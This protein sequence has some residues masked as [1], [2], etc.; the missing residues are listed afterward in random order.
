MIKIV[1][2]YEGYLSL[3]REAKLLESKKDDESLENF[4]YRVYK[5]HHGKL[6]TI[7]HHRIGSFLEMGVITP[8]GKVFIC[9]YQ[10]LQNLQSE[11]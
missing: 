9:G 4:V 1:N 3:Y 6:I 11:N 10:G 2:A 7:G 5:R 8:E